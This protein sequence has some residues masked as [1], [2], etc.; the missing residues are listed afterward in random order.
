MV[1]KRK[2]PNKLIIINHFFKKNKIIL[3]KYVY[4]NTAKI[5]PNKLMTILLLERL[6]ILTRYELMDRK[7]QQKLQ[8]AYA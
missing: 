3:I 8:K 6:V 2:Y 4:N 1:N 5:Y 7:T